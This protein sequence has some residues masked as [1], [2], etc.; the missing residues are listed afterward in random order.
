MA[1]THMK[2]D[3]SFF[4][5]DPEYGVTM[6]HRLAIPLHDVQPVDLMRRYEWWSEDLTTRSI[7]T[8]GDGVRDVLGTIR[9][10]NQPTQLK[11]MLRLALR[12]DL[13]L[14]YSYAG[15]DYDVKLVAVVGASGLDDVPLAPDRARAGYGEWEV[16]VHLRATGSTTTLDGIFGGSNTE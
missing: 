8:I 7:V 4:F 10:D 9:M 16:R 2:G 12:E 6:E 14:R 13:T 5:D 15:V 11:R 1:T 3:A